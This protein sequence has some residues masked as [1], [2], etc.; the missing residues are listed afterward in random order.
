MQ[1][2]PEQ[3]DLLIPVTRL[4][5]YLAAMQACTL[6]ASRLQLQPNEAF[7]LAAIA[8]AAMVVGPMMLRSV[9]VGADMT[10][11]ADMQTQAVVTVLGRLLRAGTDDPHPALAAAASSIFKP[12]GMIRWLGTVSEWLTAGVRRPGEQHLPLRCT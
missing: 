7:R 11:E 1:R 12:R 2:R 8:R 6:L 4:R 9:R 3:A 10:W 5:V